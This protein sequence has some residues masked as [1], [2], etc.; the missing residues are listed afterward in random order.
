MFFTSSERLKNTNEYKSVVAII[1]KLDQSGVMWL[2][3]GHC[4]SMAEIVRTALTEVGIKTRI[5]ECQMMLMNN[6]NDPPFISTVGYDGVCNPGEI[7]TH[8]VCVTD[9][10]IP[11]IIDASI[12]HRLPDQSRIVVDELTSQQNGIFCDIEVGGIKLIYQQKNNP[13]VALQ[14]QQSILERMTTDK[15]VFDNIKVLKALV[16]LAV[17][18]SGLNAA[19]GFYDHYQ[20]YYNDQ[21]KVGISAFEEIE[22]RFDM[23]DHKLNSLIQ[24]KFKN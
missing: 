19:R 9:T 6:T 3:R 5:V 21:A 18:V 13:K 7:D 1:S 24:E 11:M 12:G 14:Y 23:I 2:G 8:V 10:P 16:L 17:V 15:K 22:D 20:K 4:I